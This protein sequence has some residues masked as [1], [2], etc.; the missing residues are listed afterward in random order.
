MRRATLVPGGEKRL[1]GQIS[2]TDPERKGHT[3]LTIKI[4]GAAENA[5][6]LC[7]PNSS[8]NNNDQAG[9]VQWTTYSISCNVNLYQ[10]LD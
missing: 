10:F 4:P 6:S 8:S 2:S 7:R 3:H 1:R 9:E 5:V